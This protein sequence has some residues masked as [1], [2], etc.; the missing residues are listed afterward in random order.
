[1]SKSF[2]EK[3]GLTKKEAQ[4]MFSYLHKAVAG[5]LTAEDRERHLK[6]D[7]MFS[8]LMILRPKIF[9]REAF[10][11]EIEQIGTKNIEETF[12]KEDM[13]EFGKY[14]S[15]FKE[16]TYYGSDEDGNRTVNDYFLDT[17]LPKDN[18]LCTM[19]DMFKNWIKENKG[20][21]K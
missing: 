9:Y 18:Q 14:M 7:P 11:D 4:F 5:T 10:E 13:I 2:F 16:E 12:T 21:N 17:S 3:Y 6:L 1:M 15:Y 19:E 20:G 8:I